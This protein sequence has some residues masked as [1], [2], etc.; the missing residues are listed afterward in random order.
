MFKV[1]F[2]A[3][4]TVA[5][6]DINAI[7]EN[8][9]EAEYPTF[10]DGV[11]YGVDA[12]NGI[13]AQMVTAGVKRGAGNNCDVS[14]S[15]TTVF[16]S[17]GTVFFDCGAVMTIDSDG[18]STEL[19]DSGQTNYVYL[20]F[21]SALNVAGARC[22]VAQPSGTDCVLLAEV[23]GTSVAQNVERFCKSRILDAPNTP[24]VVYN[25][26]EIYYEDEESETKTEQIA[27][28]DLAK[29]SMVRITYVDYKYLNKPTSN[30]IIWTKLTGIQAYIDLRSDLA[31]EP[32]YVGLEMGQ[33]PSSYNYQPTWRIAACATG[34]PINIGMTYINSEK[35]QSSNA[36]LKLKFDFDNDIL[37]I[38]STGRV[39][40]PQN[41]LKLELFA[42]EVQ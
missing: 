31:D 9:A 22:T 7:G 6:A 37:S 4:Q 16:I 1:N 13:T 27:I 2:M 28:S 30:I 39:R 3:N 38:I 15:G 14:L 10:A 12:L 8:I 23:T 42:G 41:G 33:A 24:L 11:T 19:E 20:F 34:N 36:Y 26:N 25:N 17:S 21:D 18:I 5:A 40:I 35:Y 29:Y 32:V